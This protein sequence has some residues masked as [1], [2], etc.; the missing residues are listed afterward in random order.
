[1]SNELL[2]ELSKFITYNSLWTLACIPPKEIGNPGKYRRDTLKHIVFSSAGRFD[3]ERVQTA[4][5][6]PEYFID[7][8]ELKCLLA[9]TAQ[10]GSVKGLSIEFEIFEPYSLGLFLQSCNI[11][12]LEAGY[13]SYFDNVPFVLK[14]EFKGQSAPGK[15]EMVGPYYF[16]IRLVTAD[17][18]VNEAGSKYKV[19]GIAFDNQAYFATLNAAF[20]DMKLI[21]KTAHE[22][23]VSHKTNSLL[24]QLTAREEQLIRD[25]KK[26]VRD[27][28]F[29]EFVP[30]DWGG[31]NPFEDENGGNLEF[32]TDS[33]GGTEVFKRSSEV[34]AE[35]GKVKREQVTINPKEKT[36]MFSQGTSLTNIIDSIVLMTK[37]I[38][39]GASDPTK[40]KDGFVTWWK[41]SADYELLD[42]DSMVGDYAKK[43]TFRIIPYKA[44]HSVYMGPQASSVGVEKL[45]KEIP[46]KYYYMYTGKNTE[47]LRFDINIKTLFFTAANPNKPENTQNTAA[48]GV[49]ASTVPTVLNTESTAEFP[50]Q[51]TLDSAMGANA[52][53][54]VRMSVVTG[55]ESFKGGT[56]RQDTKQKVANEFYMNAL[57]KTVD[58]V[59]LELEIMGDPYWLPENGFGNY[60]PSGN[61]TSVAQ[62]TANIESRD[63][64]IHVTFRNPVDVINAKGLL[65]FQYGITESPFSGI[66]RVT[67]IQ[68]NWQ[69]GLYKC[70][71][72]GLRLPA[73]EKS[74]GSPDANTMPVKLGGI[75]PK[76]ES[77][78]KWGGSTFNAG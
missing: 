19:K 38:R 6:V 46:K 77:V 8:I 66:Y 57:T 7:N 69:N 37:E 18:T 25:K 11:A 12:A 30:A 56:G 16:M 47:V 55:N 54:P 72:K 68:H 33:T 28:Y 31:P 4:H 2:N 70:T 71:L 44:H 48:P 17:F 10:T 15:F 29:I 14:L 65:E 23:L 41:V 61:G 9:A 1:M 34:T 24:S 67:E 63:I 59:N 50:R 45:K 73:Q 21:G 64:F 20:N 35:D 52:S 76:F 3:K 40:M 13:K 78:I 27:Q 36:F 43:V 62:E 74:P 22:V 32:D 42:Y 58:M 26:T 51:P 5:G 53:P 60:H 49:N 39:D 75:V